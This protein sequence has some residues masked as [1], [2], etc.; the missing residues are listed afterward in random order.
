MCLSSSVLALPL[1]MTRSPGSYAWNWRV[2]DSLILG[3]VAQIGTPLARCSFVAC[4][5]L[6]LLIVNSHF[7]RFEFEGF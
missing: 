1:D 3:T 7:Y 6:F 4:T 2:S 5:Q